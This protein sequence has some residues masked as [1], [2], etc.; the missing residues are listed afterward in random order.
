MKTTT[1]CRIQSLPHYGYPF[2]GSEAA[3]VL[4]YGHTHCLVLLL[5]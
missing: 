1:L 3:R 2:V 4:F 5:E